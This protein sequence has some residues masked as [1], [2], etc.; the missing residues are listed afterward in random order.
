MNNPTTS[1]KKDKRKA[2]KGVVEEGAAPEQPLTEETIPVPQP[3]NVPQGPIEMTPDDLADE[4][5]GPV[6]EKG[7]KA[8]KGKAKKTKGNED[9]DVSASG[10]CL[11]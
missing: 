10:E 2:K 6:G 4:E 9:G 11:C 7:K 8:K 5:W 1:N 3:I